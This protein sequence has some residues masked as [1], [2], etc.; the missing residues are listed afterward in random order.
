M[1]VYEV[2]VEVEPSVHAEYRAWL[3]THVAELLAL[4]GFTGATT[5]DVLEPLSEDGWRATCV[6]YRLV[7]EDALAA[8][9]REHAPRLRADGIARFGTR[10]RA[11]RRVMRV[12]D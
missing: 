3:G 9:L 2:C 4:P 11:Q 8:Y 12:A 5:F 1:L 10:M 6:H 7:D